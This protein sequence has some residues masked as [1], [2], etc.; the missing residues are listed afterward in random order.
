V[1]KCEAEHT[2]QCVQLALFLVA[3][4]RRARRRREY[5]LV[6][7]GRPPPINEG[8]D[9]ALRGFVARRAAS[10]PDTWH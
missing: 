6:E 1:L 2:R 4:L 3:S 10:M 9:E 7:Y 8:G 5:A